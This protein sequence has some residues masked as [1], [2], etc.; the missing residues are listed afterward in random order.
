MKTAEIKQAILKI[1]ADADREHP[2]RSLSF[3][4]EDTETFGISMGAIAAI[5]T[6]LHD[7]GHIKREYEE[8]VPYCK[9]TVRGIE[10]LEDLQGEPASPSGARLDAAL[11]KLKEAQERSKRILEEDEAGHKRIEEGLANRKEGEDLPDGAQSFLPATTVK[12]MIQRA[13]VKLR[14]EFIEALEAIKG[15]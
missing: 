7:S 14:G 12:F 9:I 1:L 11:A 6:D 8:G 3:G 4:E 10:A 15:K 13:V 2:E 5:L